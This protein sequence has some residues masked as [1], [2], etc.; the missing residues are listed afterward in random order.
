MPPRFDNVESVEKYHPGGFHPVQIGDVF[1]KGRYEVL[2]KLGFGGFST[3]WLARDLQSRQHSTGRGRLVSLKIMLAEESRWPASD[4]P[5]VC[6]P[7]ELT[8]LAHD[9]GHPGGAHIRMYEDV[10]VHEGPNG[11][12]LCLVSEFAGPS[13]SGVHFS[14]GRVLGSR[15]LRADLAR[16]VARQLVTA[17]DLLHTAGVV[18]GGLL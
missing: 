14:P 5:D 4:I 16:K 6:I 9:L 7:R 2:H 18:H 10:F 15:R 17:V 12:H 8:R 13:L 1:A 11:Q 3:I